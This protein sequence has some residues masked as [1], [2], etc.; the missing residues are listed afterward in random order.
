MKILKENWAVAAGI[1]CPRLLSQRSLHLCHAISDNHHQ[2]RRPLLAVVVSM[3][4]F[5]SCKIRSTHSEL[6]SSNSTLE[7][8]HR[9]YCGSVHDFRV[10]A[11]S[12]YVL[13]CWLA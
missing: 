9:Y 5:R 6:P 4:S 2:H 8:I 11:E 1:S 3:L 7:E 12:V 13:A 10:H